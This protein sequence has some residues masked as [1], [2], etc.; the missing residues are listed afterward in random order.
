MILKASYPERIKF[1]FIDGIRTEIFNYCFYQFILLKTN[2]GLLPKPT[3]RKDYLE[4]YFYDYAI[5]VCK[6]NNSIPVILKICHP[7]FPSYPCN[8][9]LN[10]LRPKAKIIDLDFDLEQKVN[11]SS[12][13][14]KD[15]FYIHAIYRK[16][17]IVFD[18]HPNEFA[19]KLFSKR[20]YNELKNR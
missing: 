14:Y 18:E 1:I 13:K 5:D 16:D 9:L 3:K 11:E 4:R 15:L 12:K 6:K 2:I 7:Y 17:T 10:Y 20:I 8:N 19:N